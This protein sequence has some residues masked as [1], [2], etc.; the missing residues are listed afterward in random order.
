MTQT[1]DSRV[2]I[3]LAG[4][5][6]IGVGLHLLAPFPSEHWALQE[7]YKATPE[8]FYALAGVYALLLFSS[9]YFLLSACLSL[10]FIL[11]PRGRQQETQIV[12][13]SPPEIREPHVLVG[14]LHNQ[15]CPEPVGDPSWLVIPERGL[16]TG[17][18][19]FGAIGSGKTSCCMYPFAKQLLVG[20]QECE[21]IGGLVLEVKG[22]FCHQV[23][24][25]LV[26][27]GRGEDYIE[28]NIGSSPFRYNPLNNNLDA[29][30]LAYGV[31]TLLTSLFGKGREPF[32]QQAYTN[33]MKFIILLHRLLHGYVTFFD[34]YECA[35]NPDL[36]KSRLEL[37]ELAMRSTKLAVIDPAFYLEFDGLARFRWET[38]SESKQMEA[39][40]SDELEQFLQENAIIHAIRE[41]DQLPSGVTPIRD[42]DRRAECEAVSRWFHQ[43]WMRIDQR[44]RTSIVEGIAFFLSLFDE[45]PALRRVFCP[46]KSCLQPGGVDATGGIALPPFSELI[47]Q[48]KVVALN[49]PISTNPGLAR[50]I[51]TM[52]KQDFQRAVLD[53]VTRMEA[54]PN[55]PWRPVLFLCDEYHMFATVGSNEPTGDEKFF[56]QS[57]Q[58]KCIPIVA[59]Q[60]VSSLKSVLSGE[61]WR[62]LLQTFR[63]K[64]FLCLSDDF[65]AQV[66]SDLC[67]RD[68]QLK[69]SYNFSESGQDAEI[70]L[71]TG[72]ATSKKASLSAS[73]NYS[74]QKDCIFEPRTFSELRNAQAI[75]LAYDGQNPH[76]PSYCFLK[77]YFLDSAVSYFEHVK[78]GRL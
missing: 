51:G 27:G 65:S 20:A 36:L 25:M 64:I 26:Q 67:G 24:E 16:Y 66:A 19:V 8:L 9:P 72:K 14:E 5:M 58:S 48:G 70:S 1:A 63:T 6:G 44:L 60:S 61:A 31:A 33:M 56:S 37:A 74:L 47:E 10:L 42:P 75:V 15:R 22:D 28:I 34:V 18:A 7:I 68:E 2:L 55:R 45:N 13:P 17:I 62:T 49:F 40:L 3:V 11:G 23:R 78:E 53:R 50:L 69:L 71:L 43:D 52:M 32:W 54:E 46:P 41:A 21:R 35:I 39:F 77:P 12:L 30:A 76:P 38:N 73:K 4:S 29:Y 57:R 59:T